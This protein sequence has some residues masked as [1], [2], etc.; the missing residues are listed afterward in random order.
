MPPTLERW[1]CLGHSGQPEW[2]QTTV[3]FRLTEVNPAVT[4][5]EFTHGGLGRSWTATSTARPGG[6]TSWEA[7]PPTLRPAPDTRYLRK[8]SLQ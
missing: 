1:T 3:T 2:A 4:R 5:L 8:R 7:S 6:I